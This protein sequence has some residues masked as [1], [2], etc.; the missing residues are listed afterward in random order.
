[1]AKVDDGREPK[2][3]ALSEKEVKAVSGDDTRARHLDDTL[4]DG[5]YREKFWQIWRPKDPPPPPPETLAEVRADGSRNCMHSQK[6]SIYRLKSFRSQARPTSS[7][8]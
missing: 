7:A 4:I 6:V 2:P 3:A 8:C 5:V 1:M